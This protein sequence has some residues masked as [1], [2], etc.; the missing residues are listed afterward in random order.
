MDSGN[1][2]TKIHDANQIGVSISNAKDNSSDV[3]V[4]R[5]V[6]GSKLVVMVRIEAFRKQRN[7]FCIVP[8]D[9]QD[10]IVQDL[11]TSQTYVDLYVPLQGILMRCRLKNTDA[12]FRY[13][14]EIPEF[15]AQVERRRDLRLNV[16]DQDELKVSFGKTITVPRVMSQFFLKSCFDISAGGLSFFVS[17]TESK[18][19]H[20]DDV[21]ST[22]EI[23]T[24]EWSAKITSRVLSVRETEPDEANGF[25]Y[26]VWRVSCQIMQIDPIAKK[27]LEKYI[28]ERIKDELYAING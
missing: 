5:F 8:A 10:R 19:F 23:K 28:F 13:Y 1:K 20:A 21:I 18:L 11:I 14:L 12:P 22:M 6:G 27:Q 24:S 15:I 17:K 16:Y 26:K 7:D 3:Y 9:G 25:P 2:L 4:W